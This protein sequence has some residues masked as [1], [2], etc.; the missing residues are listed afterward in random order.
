MATS[1][2]SLAISWTSVFGQNNPAAQMLSDISFNTFESLQTQGLD[3]QVAELE[4]QIASLQQQQKAWSVLQT[5]AQ[6]FG[7]SVQALGT[8]SA[9]TAMTASAGDPNVA[10]VAAD[11]SAVAGTY[12]VDVQQLALQEIDGTAPSVALTSTGAALGTLNPAWTAATLAF[13]VGTSTYS[14]AVTASTT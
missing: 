4:Q 8:S 1:P 3:T 11:S 12:N 9:W 13:T 2:P 5:D 7:T 10:A 14:L 6:A